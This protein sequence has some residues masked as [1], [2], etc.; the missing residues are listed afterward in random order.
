MP[1]AMSTGISLAFLL[2]LMVGSMLGLLW[3]RCLRR[4][5]NQRFSP[6]AWQRIDTRWKILNDLLKRNPLPGLSRQ[7]VF[8]MLGR[9]DDDQGRIALCF[10]ESE[11]SNYHH[12]AYKLSEEDDSDWLVVHLDENDRVADCSRVYGW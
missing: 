7:Q 5:L 8:D 6:T 12:V 9:P 10:A 1:V 3:D 2:L 4:Q 11:K